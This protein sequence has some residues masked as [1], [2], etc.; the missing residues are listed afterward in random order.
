[1]NIEVLERS[2][3]GKSAGARRSIADTKLIQAPFY[4][5]IEIEPYQ[6]DPVA[7]GADAAR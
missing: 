3:L 4:S 5:G 2:S 1:L 6:L 7:R